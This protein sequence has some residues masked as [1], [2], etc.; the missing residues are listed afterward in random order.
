VGGTQ[1]AAAGNS[2]QVGVWQ[3][4]SSVSGDALST[5]MVDYPFSD[6]PEPGGA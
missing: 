1:N 6:S 5:F 3:Y 4:C 2:K